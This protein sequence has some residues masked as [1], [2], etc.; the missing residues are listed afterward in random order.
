M[1]M[2]ESVPWLDRI[3]TAHLRPTYPHANNSSQIDPTQKL[4]TI[5]QPPFQPPSV[6]SSKQI[7]DGNNYEQTILN[8]VKNS[9]D[10]AITLQHLP[11]QQSTIQQLGL[12]IVHAFSTL[13]LNSF[14]K[15]VLN[16][17][18]KLVHS[19]TDFTCLWSYD[20]LLPR[21][22]IIGLLLDNSLEVEMKDTD[23]GIFDAE[24]PLRSI[25][26]FRSDHFLRRWLIG[27]QRT[28]RQVAPINSFQFSRA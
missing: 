11:Q 25:W 1:H 19:L 15:L 28:S 10:S 4:C 8:R 16:S 23:G 17:F 6:F 22:Q 26:I 9:K 18:K 3:F 14:K 2:D 20:F 21:D 7:R 5:V 24:L 27:H 13:I 12:G